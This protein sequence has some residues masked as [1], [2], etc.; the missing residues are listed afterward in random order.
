M[1]LLLDV[2]SVD[3]FLIKFED[4]RGEVPVA[5][6]GVPFIQLGTEVR[7]C[8]QGPDR[9]KKRKEASLEVC[10]AVSVKMSRSLDFNLLKLVHSS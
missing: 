2:Q 3:G 1:Y 4:T 10:T 7:E 9:K 6:D 8:H 5:Y